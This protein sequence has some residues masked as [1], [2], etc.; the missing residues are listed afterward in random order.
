MEVYCVH[1]GQSY[2]QRFEANASVVKL[3]V[4]KKTREKNQ[5]CVS[6]LPEYQRIGMQPEEV[7]DELKALLS[8]RAYDASACAPKVKVSL[9]GNR[10]ARSPH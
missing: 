3:P 8:M 5:V 2:R 1:D 10:L 4:L 7:R 6:W 9:N